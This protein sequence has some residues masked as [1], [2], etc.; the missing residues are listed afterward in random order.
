MQ[1]LNLSESQE[2]NLKLRIRAM[3]EN[4]LSPYKAFET[5]LTPEQILAYRQKLEEAGFGEPDTQTEDIYEQLIEDLRDDFQ[6]CG[7]NPLNRMPDILLIAPV[8]SETQTQ[9][10]VDFLTLEIYESLQAFV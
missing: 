7:G 9:E 4:S 1:Q 6:N 8:L 2:I 10:L 3:V 5:P